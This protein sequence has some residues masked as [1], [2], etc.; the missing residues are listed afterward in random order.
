MHSQFRRLVNM[1]RQ[2][3]R[4]RVSQCPNPPNA[5]KPPLPTPIRLFRPTNFRPSFCGGWVFRSSSTRCSSFCRTWIFFAKDLEGRFIIVSQRM[6]ARVGLAREEDLIGKRDDAIHP[7]AV[8][9]AIR[10]DDA[11]VMR[12]RRP[13]VDRVEAL[14][15]W[16][17]AKSWFLTTKLPIVDDLGEVIGIMGYVRPYHSGRGGVE[18]DPQLRQVVDHLQTHFSKEIVIESLA[19]LAHLSVRQLRRRFQKAFRM[20]P[21]EFVVRTR[22]QAAVQ[23]L[24]ESNTPIAEIAIT[25]GFYDQS[26]FT[27]Q[28]RQHIGETPRVFREKRARI[29]DGGRGEK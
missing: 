18:D 8:V 24:L 19:N 29:G 21:Q 22:V 23:T 7:P 1:E 14:Y 4:G 2:A 13:L 25:H 16:S 5:R 17:N 6:L 26:A 10:A 20:S 12:S 11:E 3:S 15:S 9:V 27:R 28:F